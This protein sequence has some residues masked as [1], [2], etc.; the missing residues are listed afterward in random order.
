MKRTVAQIEALTE[1]SD[2]QH[3]DSV[4]QVAVKENEEIFGKIKEEENL[5]EAL[6]KL[7]EPEIK[8]EVDKAVNEAVDKA[9]KGAEENSKK[10]IILNALKAGNSVVR[11]SVGVQGLFF[12]FLTIFVNK[13]YNTFTYE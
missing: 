9:V 5:C 11:V 2:K 13:W 12:I 4:L 6:R 10:N 3:G 7:V 8:E 1:E